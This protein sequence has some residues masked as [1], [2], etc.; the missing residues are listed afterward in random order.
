MADVADPVLVRRAQLGRLAKVGKRLGYLALLAAIVAFAA[1]MASGLP[2][3]SMTVVVAAMLVATLLLVPTII[4]AYA[5]KKA[6]RED[7]TPPPGR[8]G[9][10]GG[11]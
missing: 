2:P 6:E 3:W 9:V 1:G 11:R 7:P 4:L 8:N 10:P 5:V